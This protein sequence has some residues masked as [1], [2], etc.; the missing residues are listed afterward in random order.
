MITF[1]G[2]IQI[3]LKWIVGVKKEQLQ[4]RMKL[5]QIQF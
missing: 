4:K 1:H 2:K 5:Y 3:I